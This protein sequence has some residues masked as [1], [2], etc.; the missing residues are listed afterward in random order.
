MCQRDFL[1]EGMLP[2]NNTAE[3]LTQDE[4]LRLEKLEIH[5][6]KSF[7]DPAQLTFPAAL[8]AVVGPN[9][10]GKSNICDA[11]IWVLGENR[12]S[13]IRGETMEDVIF[14][15]S[16]LRRPLS[17]GE[18]TLTL[19]TDNGHPAADDG[20]IT[21]N[22]RVFRT[23][24][25][26]FRM[27]G[28]RVRMKDIS[29]ILMDTGLGIRN[30]SVMEQGKIDLILSNKPQ[31]RRRLIEEAAG[32]TKYKT[33]RR[34]AEM[35]LEETQANLLRIDDTLAEVTRNLNSLKRQ[36]GKARRHRELSEQLSTAK[37]ALYKGRLVA[38]QSEQKT[39]EEGV[40]GAQT[41]EGTLAERL[42]HAEGTL[43][44]HRTRL[45]ARTT[46]AANVREEMAALNGEVERLRSFLQQ[47]EINISDLSQRIDN[48]RGQIAEL[49]AEAAQQQALLHQ[50]HDALE[51]ARIERN[52][53]R[54]I[55]DQL[56]HQR[57]E[58]SDEVRTHE[59]SLSDARETLMQ[60]IAKISEARN[61]VHQIEVA[62]E[63]CEFYLGKLQEAAR[64]ATDSRDFAKMTLSEQEV[65]LR[66]AEQALVDA[67]HRAQNAVAHRDELTE[68]RDAM[69]ESLASARDRVSQ[70]TYK[71]DS[72]RTLLTSLE[73]QDE[74]VRSAILEVIPNASAAAEAVRA[75]EGYEAAL[76]T[77]LR[78]VS[79]AVVVDNGQTAFDA[80]AR[81]RQ[82]GAGRGAFVVLDYQQTGEGSRRGDAAFAVVGEG[83]VADAVRHA[84]P[85]AYIVGDLQQAL[86][87]AKDRPSATFVTLEGDIVRGPLV[88]GGKTEGATPGVFSLK[89]QLSDLQSLLGTEETRATGIA[90][91]LQAVEEEL[92]AADDARIIAEERARNA[93][94]DL[95]D[96]RSDRERAGVELDRFERDL[97]VAS[98]EQT[99][100]VEEKDQL[101]ARRTAAIA[102]LQWLE[103]RERETHDEI[104]RHEDALAT[105]RTEF[106]Q[107]TDIASKGRV[108][109]EAAT[110]NVTAVQREFDNLSR[111]VISLTSRGTQLQM[112][113]DALIQ[114]RQE[115]TA[116]ADDSR[117]QLED[118]AA[119][120]Q[121]LTET[122][123]ALEMEVT[124][125]ERHVLE[126]QTAS[127]QS[128]EQWNGA[129]DALFEAERRLDRARSAF[130]LLREQIALDLHAGVDTLAD[131]DAPADEQARA[132]LESEVARL[133]EHLE[134]VGPVN[135]LAIEES[136]ELEER[137]TLL[138]TQRD[139]LVQAIES[140]R[141]TIRKVN[142]TSRDLFREAFASVNHS[143][144]EI[145]ASLFG[146]G[147]ARM[148]LLDEE[149]MLESGI[150]LIAQPPGKR[151]QSIALLSGGERALTAL[152]LLFAIFRYKPSPFCILD[153]VDAPLDEVNNERFVRLVRDMAHETQ[154]IVITHSRRTME[155]ADVLYGVTM[156]EA[157]C[158]RLVSVNF[159]EIE[160]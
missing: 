80:V 71:I 88:I 101:V 67:Q 10:C 114:K 152:A 66:A 90:A 126:L 56:E 31:D 38:A 35:K 155:A 55:A 19:K 25:S 110:G 97:A 64:R 33:K 103:T 16:A 75:A 128:R 69:R 141:A 50:Q 127:T 34:A 37:R 160:A 102:D 148:Q 11:I 78:E 107:I 17:M 84:M 47:S 65:A 117:R 109:V 57:Q 12:A 131:I 105:A 83:A 62:V 119:K 149:D 58:K 133:L 82:R 94:T 63:K 32:I 136:Q 13:H 68:R 36:A 72:L 18:V 121:E 135:V 79:K 26:E 147:T 22:R 120:L 2:S 89:R 150:E 132:D 143:F 153:E 106:E 61:Q 14:Q 157:G 27:N 9:G 125:L 124:D 39:A 5:G 95:H 112:E 144:G 3:D 122:R 108:D 20:R 85:E 60:T 134:R 1:L 15:G 92:H 51:S 116:A 40:S 45:A 54:D 41:N 44:E 73:S 115:T 76:D 81:L 8:T 49:E 43:D 96:R 123:T 86:E 156:E 30:Y 104:R 70:T 59:K 98:E 154:F 6:F 100:Y 46:R 4:M 53:V 129:K 42:A 113:I 140:L 137:E 7:Y 130:E 52:R 48:A 139:D 111:V 159:A 29:D 91:E 145:F 138:R 99:L 158:S 28:R 24:E 87:R 151:N 118:A 146:G 21:L 142:M 74:E 93:E 77:L 23:G